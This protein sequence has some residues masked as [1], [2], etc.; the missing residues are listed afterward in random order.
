MCLALALF[1]LAWD[2]DEQKR[3]RGSLTLL[4]PRRW[5]CVSVLPSCAT[6][7][8]PR[9][10]RIP[11][12]HHISINSV[13]KTNH[14]QIER[15]ELAA[16]QTARIRIRGTTGVSKTFFMTRCAENCLCVQTTSPNRYPKKKKKAMTRHH[17]AN[18]HE[19]G[20]RKK[21]IP[22]L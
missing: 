21:P 3:I 14:I 18:I 19:I 10:R 12:A 20:K 15:F 8:S 6:V 9:R 4:D 5:I 2:D 22:Y 17:N 11:G 13:H 1:N 7:E 16:R